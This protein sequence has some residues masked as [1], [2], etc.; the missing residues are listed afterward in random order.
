MMTKERSSPS[1]MCPDDTSEMLQPG[2]EM[3]PLMGPEQVPDLVKQLFGLNVTSVTTLN[4]YD[5]KN[6]HI[7]VILTVVK[8]FM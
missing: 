6:F 7:Q 1:D 3:R 2:D 8:T 4:S 5:D